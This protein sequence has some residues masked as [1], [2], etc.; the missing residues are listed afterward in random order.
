MLA[1]LAGFLYSRG[2]DEVSIIGFYSVSPSLASMGNRVMQSWWTV[3][4]VMMLMVGSCTQGLLVRTRG[5]RGQDRTIQV[6]MIH[7]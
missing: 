4:M 3:M 6:I 5:D 2:R 1:L 7:N